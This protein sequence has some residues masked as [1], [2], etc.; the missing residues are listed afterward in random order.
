MLRRIDH[1]FDAAKSKSASVADAVEYPQMIEYLT[2][3]RYP[4]GSARK[5]SSL[6]VLCDGQSWR[7]CLSDRD[8]ERVLWKA[9]P[10]LKDALEAIELSL[11][12][13]DPTE[14]RRSA[15]AQGKKKK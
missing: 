3:E 9:G 7:V 11:L 10:T 13:D 14:W 6:V 4:D 1:S 12:G 5:P 2:A 8:N 15:D